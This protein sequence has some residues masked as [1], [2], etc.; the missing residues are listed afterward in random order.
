MT[1]LAP[2]NF[3]SKYKWQIYVQFVTTTKLKMS[4]NCISESPEINIR[5]IIKKPVILNLQHSLQQG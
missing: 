5:V 3:N 1:K 4:V 2:I